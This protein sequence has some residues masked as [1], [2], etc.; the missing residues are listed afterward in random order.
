MTPYLTCDAASEL[1]QG[2]VDD[3]LVMAERVAVE[4]HLRWC[5]VCEARVTDMR[6]IGASLRMVAHAA[7]VADH[8]SLTAVQSGVLAKLRAE[9]DQSFLAQCKDMFADMRLFWPA[10]GAS[11]AVVTCLFAATGVFEA[12]TVEDHPNSMAG[13]IDMLANPGS[14]SNPMSL[15][16]RLSAPRALDAAAVM[17]SIA[18]EDA[19]YAFSAVVTR[20]GRVSNYELLL[21]ERASVRRRDKAAET[22]GNAA[23]LL[24]AVKHSRFEPA[25]TRAGGAVAVNMVWLL[26]RTTVRGSTRVELALPREVTRPAP[27]V[28]EKTIDELPAV[29]EPPASPSPTA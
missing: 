21:S 13:M 12:A 20:E 26:A 1:L 18:E 2:F 4:S 16:S 29:T 25:Q 22:D 3:E 10:L 17:G 6:L 14:D 8:R 15:D 24:A 23:A 27:R 11:I 28:R 5:R 9:R 19:V 7:P